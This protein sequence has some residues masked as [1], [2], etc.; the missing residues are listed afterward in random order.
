MQIETKDVHAGMAR[1]GDGAGWSGQVVHGA[2]GAG[3]VGWCRGTS[4]QLICLVR[5][6]INL[7]SR[8]G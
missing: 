1:G 4:G 2:A 8:I 5:A 6:S 3:L 7:E